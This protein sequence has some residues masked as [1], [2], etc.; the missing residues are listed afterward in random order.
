LSE[1]KLTPHKGIFDYYYAITAI[2]G[3]E[4]RVMGIVQASKFRSLIGGG[5][6]S[7]QHLIYTQRLT[8]GPWPEI[9]TQSASKL[10]L[11]DLSQITDTQ[12]P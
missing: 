8:T 3:A 6:F 10:H 2:C 5:F 11:R 9:T 4:G 7:A 12:S 1:S